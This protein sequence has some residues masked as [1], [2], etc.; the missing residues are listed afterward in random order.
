MRYGRP[1]SGQKQAHGT[2]GCLPPPASREPGLVARQAK[3]AAMLDN[4]A[5]GLTLDEIYKAIRRIRMETA[6]PVLF[7]E[8]GSGC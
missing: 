4:Q 8:T 3:V 5:G 1:Q 7:G 6:T 2:K